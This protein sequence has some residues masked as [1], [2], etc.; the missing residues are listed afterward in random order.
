MTD[1]QLKT[2]REQLA[3][4]DDAG[5]RKYAEEAH[6]DISGA[7]TR[8]D[9][10]ALIEREAVRKAEAAAA[11][12]SP[13]QPVKAGG[14]AKTGR[15]AMGEDLTD[16]HISAVQK[17]WA[18]WSRNVP[19]TAMSQGAWTLDR[20]ARKEATDHGVPDGDYRVLGADWILTF[21]GGRFIEAIKA[22]PETRADSYANVPGQDDKL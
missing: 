15:R 19:Q 12:K 13:R 6:V 10:E 1:K 11:A 17:V 8:D 5:L 18:W 9:V 3:K 20:D 2:L 7:T 4:L 14:R 16:E 22:S 21:A